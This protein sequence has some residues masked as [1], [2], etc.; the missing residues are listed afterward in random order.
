MIWCPIRK[1]KTNALLHGLD[2]GA[3]SPE[4]RVTVQHEEDL[5]LPKP[6][7]HTL[8]KE[9]KKCPPVIQALKR[10]NF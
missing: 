3:E 4:V 10:T 8:I 6:M 5:H 1:R 7:P 2:L 9:K